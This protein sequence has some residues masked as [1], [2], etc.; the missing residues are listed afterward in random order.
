MIK[1]ILINEIPN[2]RIGQ[3]E[4][5]EGGT[6]C[7]VF[8][9]ESGM[10]CGL[11]VRGGGPASRE[12]LLVSPLTHAE[13]VHAVLLSGGSAYGLEASSGVMQYLE[14][15]GIG[16]D[17]GNTVVPLVCQ[18]ALFD[19]AYRSK[20]ARPDKKMGYDACVASESGNYMDGC[21]GAGTGATVGK[22]YGMERSTK[23]GIGSFA[24]DC[25]GLMVGA[26]VAV[27]AYG[28]IYDAERGDFVAG[29]KNTSLNGFIS[30]AEE[31]Y[32][33]YK[34]VYNKFSDNTTLGVVI[35]NAKFNKKELC[36]IAGMSHNG[37]ARAIY[38]VH[39]SVDG[40]SIYA[41]SVG[42]IDAD[43]DVVGTLA[44]DV[45]EQAILKAAKSS[46]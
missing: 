31:M 46:M 20:D 9:S 2:I 22:Y 18:S 45:V 27:N 14:E 24:V 13:M 6:G 40:D 35:T 37:F 8:I 41:V 39:T 29:L 28:D 26:V 17:V 7:T 10:P 11:D 19:L 42:K 43:M 33:N 25:D 38:P 1:E 16:L 12:S 5:I 23:S 30:T 4:D 44:A 32:K 21:H 36:K 3:S 34:P 15:K